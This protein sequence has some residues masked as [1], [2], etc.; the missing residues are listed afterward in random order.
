MSTTVQRDLP[1]NSEHSANSL[2]PSLV[3]TDWSIPDDGFSPLSG[4]QNNVASGWAHERP[5]PTSA[6]SK[7]RGKLVGGAVMAGA[8]ALGTAAYFLLSSAPEK[9]AAP[10]GTEVPAP[11]SQSTAIPIPET[12]AAPQAIQ[13][14]APEPSST[15]Q[16]D[17][18]SA[19]PTFAWPDPPAVTPPAQR[20]RPS[21]PVAPT[22]NTAALRPAGEP[23]NRDILFLQRPSVNI[24]SAPS[25]TG[26]ILGT[27][28]QG[29][30]FEVTS[31]EGD[32]VQVESGRFKGWISGRFLG[33]DEPR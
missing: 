10:T 7:P 24:R 14:G 12:Q 17:A 28:P 16:R 22:N 33:P 5:F 26:K 6:E 18:P 9:T 29:T 15:P 19:P 30:R 11:G 2:A 13:A 21:A 20:E 23:Q 3:P 4:S 32:W 25:A 8:V 31:R 1:G 27:A